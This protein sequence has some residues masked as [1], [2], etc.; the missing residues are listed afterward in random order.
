[1]SDEGGPIR[2]VVVDDH[3][4]VRE[5]LRMMLDVAGKGEFAAVGEA[6][7]GAGALRTIGETEPEVVLMDLRMPGMDGLE[8]IAHI[9][10]RWPR[11]AVI[12]LTTYDEDDLL[13]RGLQAGARS[14]LL[15]DTDRATVFHAIRTVARGGAM[16]QT[17]MLDRLLAYTTPAVPQAGASLPSE[18]MIPARQVELTARERE[19]L[20]GVAGGERN[21][22]IAARLGIATRTVVTHLTNIYTKLEVDSRAAAVAIALER[23]LLRRHT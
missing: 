19:I 11:V 16:L 12:I 15:K 23:G 10:T 21:K 7:D 17:G 6:A 2:V 8:A 22:E 4:V 3:E 18:S 13:Y 1:M 9:R 20:A 14:Y 5:G